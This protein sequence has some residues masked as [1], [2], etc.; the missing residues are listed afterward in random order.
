PHR[1]SGQTSPRPTP[2]ERGKRKQPTTDRK[3]NGMNSNSD[4]SNSG[5]APK[6]GLS[7]TH[8]TV[9]EETIL[10]EFALTNRAMMGNGHNFKGPFW[11]DL[12]NQF[13]PPTSGKA[14]TAD[15]CREKWK[16]I[17][18]IFKIVD[19]IVTNTSGFMYTLSKGA[20]IGPA[21]QHVWVE[22]L[23]H[24]KGASKFNNKGWVHYEKLRQL[25]PSKSKG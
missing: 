25:L 14:K 20:D 22:F 2:M 9:E 6:P 17:Q 7:S 10:L 19:K 21:S 8:W 23:K 11:N 13:P 16:R 18:A 15:S 1:C 4:H 12:A 3:D 24:T 5:P